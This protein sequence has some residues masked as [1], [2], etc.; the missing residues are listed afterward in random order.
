MPAIIGFICGSRAWGGL[1][2]NHLNHC[3]WMKNNDFEVLMLCR[4]DSP[5]A[6]ESEATGIKTIYIT[7][8]RRYKYIG[9]SFALKKILATESIT[10]LVAR[11]PND[12]NICGIAKR[13]LKKKIHLSYFMEM[14]L[15]VSKKN[16]LHTARFRQINSWVCSLPY[17]KKQVLELTRFPE[18]KIRVIPSALNLLKIDQKTNK[19]NAR[20]NLQLPQDKFILGL[21]GRIDS[22]KGQHTLIEALYLLDNSAF[23]ICLMGEPTRNE[24]ND[25]YRSILKMI[26]DYHL[27]K[28]VFILSFDQKVNDFF[29]AIDVS[30][31][32]SKSETFGMVSIESLAYGKPVIGSKSGGTP[33]I[34]SNDKLGLLFETENPRDLADKINYLYLNQA[35]FETENLKSASQQYDQDIIYNCILKEVF[36]L[37]K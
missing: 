21:L 20:Q 1:E 36:N 31:M 11:N 9:A 12:L 33:E 4:K 2:M 16:F 25:Y 26:K 32:A 22:L 3:L 29:Q 8:H 13:L 18:N 7:D 23:A 28:N 10:H 17:L 27:E 15:G 5:I 19:K 24:S 34:I 6:K 14:Q 37:S 30:I 35:Q